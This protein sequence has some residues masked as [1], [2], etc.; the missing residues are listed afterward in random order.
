MTAGLP[1]RRRCSECG[2]EFWAIRHDQRFCRPKCRR[3][4]WSW[5]ESQGGRAIELLIRW[6][7]DRRPGSIAELAAFA[8]DLLHHERKRE[9]QRA[10]AGRGEG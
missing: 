7:R 6:R 5:R 2:K 3:A 8:D 10:A 4:F 1:A 9:V